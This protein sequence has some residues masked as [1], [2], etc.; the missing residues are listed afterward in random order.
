MYWKSLTL[1][2]F[3]S[4]CSF[5]LSA[6]GSDCWEVNVWVYGTQWPSKRCWIPPQWI[7][8]GFWQLWQVRNGREKEGKWWMSVPFP[9]AFPCRNMTRRSVTQLKPAIA[10]ARH[11][12]S[13]TW[14]LWWAEHGDLPFSSKIDGTF[15]HSR[16]QCVA[17]SLSLIQL[18]SC[19][20]SRQPCSAGRVFS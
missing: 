4:L 11:L 3:K 19:V 12:D 10:R 15:C 17:P 9:D 6:V 18:T 14:H 5:L 13:R 7:P 8:F 20:N 2:L 1:N 16:N